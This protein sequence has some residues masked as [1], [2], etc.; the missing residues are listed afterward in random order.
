MIGADGVGIGVTSARILIPVIRDAMPQ[1]LAQ[2]LA[3]VQPMTGAGEIFTLKKVTQKERQPHQ[4]E[5]MHDFIRG[6]LRYYGSQW[7]PQQLWIKIKL[8]G[9]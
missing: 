2:E 7:I 3:G 8:K 1:L 4:G 5:W 6:H 9:F